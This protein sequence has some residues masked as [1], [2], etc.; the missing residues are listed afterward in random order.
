M[1]ANIFPPNSASWTLFRLDHNAK[2]WNR[3]KLN[4]SYGLWRPSTMLQNVRGRRYHRPWSGRKGRFWVEVSTLSKAT[5]VNIATTVVRLEKKSPWRYMAFANGRR[6]ASSTLPFLCP[7]LYNAAVLENNFKL[8]NLIIHSW[9][10]A[11]ATDILQ[12]VVISSL[13]RSLKIDGPID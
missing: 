8:L 10:W 7:S 3:D 9:T 12:L 5:T 2:K 1:C 11:Y 4:Y 6:P 13:H